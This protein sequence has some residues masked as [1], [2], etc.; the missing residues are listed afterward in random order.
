MTPSKQAKEYGALSLS[1]VS[2][3][4]GYSVDTL[5][6]YHKG[7]PERFEALCVASVCHE[8]RV[9]GARLRELHSLIESLKVFADGSA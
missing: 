3:F 8:L 6:T 5:R 1:A 4:S 2:A 9:D 7:K